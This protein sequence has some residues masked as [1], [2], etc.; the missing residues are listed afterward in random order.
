MGEYGGFSCIFAHPLGD[1]SV[2]YILENTQSCVLL[3]GKLA[4]A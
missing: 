2:M 1:P 3:D 4:R